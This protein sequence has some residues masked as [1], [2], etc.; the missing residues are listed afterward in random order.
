[1]KKQSFFA[2]AVIL[3]TANAVSKILGAVFKIPLTY[4]LSEEGMAVYNTAFS[5]YIMFLSFVISG[6]PTAVSKNVAQLEEKE[7][8]NI[9]GV[10]TSI[11]LVIGALASAAIYI[12]ADFF[13]AAMKE[14]SAAQA[15]RIIAP[16]IFFVAAGAAYKSFF[17]GAS[18][19]I[20]PAVS[21]V[22]EAFVKLAAGYYLAV[23]FSQMGKSMGAAGAIG[24]VTVGEFIA[25]AILMAGYYIRKRNIKVKCTMEEKRQAAK[26]IIGV[27]LPI[28][29]TAVVSNVISVTDTSV[30]RNRLLASGLSEEEARFL[31]GAYTGYAMTVFNLPVGILGTIGVSMLSATAS[32]VASGDL[33][34][35]QR[36]VHSGLELT[37]FI[38]VPCA[39]IMYIMPEEILNI[40]FK[41]TSSA[42]MLK[43]LAPCVVCLSV[44]QMMSSALQACGRII[45][46]NVV[47]IFG[48][49]LKLGLV[50][51]F[52]GKPQYNIYGAAIS[53]NI[54]FALVMGA[55]II[56]LKKIA[57]IKIG[58]ISAAAKPLAAGGVMAAAVSFAKGY[59]DGSFISTAAV[60]MIGGTLY[61][62]I[63]YI[64]NNRTKTYLTK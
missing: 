39:V 52:V 20:P 51:Y 23:V 13:A 28:L 53:S 15:I 44:I 64:F 18:D 31:Y 47:M 61:L 63:M 54:V 60:C 48:G 38:S 50:W 25:T 22:V 40:L 6:I 5:V 11:L 30:L 24:G 2:G 4:I 57:G 42:F 62:L 46:P 9:T 12:G 19:M 55:D 21:Q 10:A 17:H 29:I 26:E 56:M 59:S 3:M 49:I 33:K 16:S 14:L 34:K 58:I 8:Y 27:A 1:M 37:L 7:A 43:M 41:N 45:L 36:P 32:A 35:A